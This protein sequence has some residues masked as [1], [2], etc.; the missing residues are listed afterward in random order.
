MPITKSAKKA[1]RQSKTR[2]AGNLKR[3]NAY[4]NVVKRFNKLTSAGKKEEAAKILSKVYQTLD[5]AAKSGVIKPN[6]AARLK[7]SAIRSLKQKTA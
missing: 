6:K 2:R 7:S 3:A 5:K 4:K 1:L